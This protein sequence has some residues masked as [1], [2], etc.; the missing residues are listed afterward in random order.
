MSEKQ[1]VTP[2][3]TIKQLKLA[4]YF[5]SF[6]CLALLVS[7]L[8][9]TSRRSKAENRLDFFLEK[10]GQVDLGGGDYDLGY[11]EGYIDGLNESKQQHKDAYDAGYEQGY[12]SKVTSDAIG[13]S[14]EVMMYQDFLREC[15]YKKDWSGLLSLLSMDP[16][17]IAK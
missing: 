2:E 3:Q 4:L 8:F 9:I 15:Y 11:N 7:V 12:E 16:D 13:R 5:L 14:L 1:D 17:K 6:I 10:Y